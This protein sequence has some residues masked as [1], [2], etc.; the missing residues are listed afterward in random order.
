MIAPLLSSRMIIFTLLL[1]MSTPVLQTQAVSP[2]IPIR[3]PYARLFQQ[4]RQPSASVTRNADYDQRPR[5]PIK[6]LKADPSADPKIVVAVPKGDYKVR[7]IQ[8]PCTE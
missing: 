5:C 1:A 3:N 2:S 8:P 6:V 7:M 4:P